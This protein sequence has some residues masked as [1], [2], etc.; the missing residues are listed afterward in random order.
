MFCSMLFV[1]DGPDSLVELTKF[2]ASYVALGLALLPSLYCSGLEKERVN[3]LLYPTRL[4][5]S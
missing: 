1:L 5:A 4:G 2:G 3:L